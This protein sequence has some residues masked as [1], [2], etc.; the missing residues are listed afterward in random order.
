MSVLRGRSKKGVAVVCRRR[1]GV[2]M[3]AGRIHPRTVGFVKWPD[4]TPFGPSPGCRAVGAGRRGWRGQAA[5]AVVACVAAG[6]ADARGALRFAAGAVTG[7]AVVGSAGP[8]VAPC[9]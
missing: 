5:T 7:R 1:P 4:A 8:V 2:N 3:A 9:D 6:G